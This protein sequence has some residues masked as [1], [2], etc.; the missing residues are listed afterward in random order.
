MYIPAPFAESDRAVLVEFMTAHPLGTLVTG[1]PANGLYATHLPL[2]YDAST[3]AHGV[4][5]GHI[6]RANP[7]HVRAQDTSACLVVFTGADAYIT[8]GWYASKARHGKV[9]PTWN[10][11]AVHVS[12]VIRFRDD[13]E[14]L[15][16]H[17]DALTT[18]HE[19]DQAHPW[20]MHDAPAHFIEQLAK[21]IVGVEIEIVSLEGKWKMSQNRADEDIDGVI[22]GLHASPLGMDQVVAA[23]VAAR[24][25]P[26]AP[27]KNS[28]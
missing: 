11:V 16:A 24:R 20:A 25:P 22:S 13:R 28:H 6:A 1:S 8:P 15:M 5:R 12:G 7:H 19:A 3:G 21:A 2:V 17:L 9:V 26:K 10:Y 23:H 14:F 4:L 18:E 27:D